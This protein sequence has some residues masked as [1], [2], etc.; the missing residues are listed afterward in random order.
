MIPPLPLPPPPQ[1]LEVPLH[2]HIPM[3]DLVPYGHGLALQLQPLSP[4]PL[5]PPIS[6][7]WRRRSVIVPLAPKDGAPLR[8]GARCPHHLLRSNLD[9]L[10]GRSWCVNI[11]YLLIKSQLTFIKLQKN[12]SYPGVPHAPPPE[13]CFT[14]RTVG[15]VVECL[16]N[17]KLVFPIT[18]DRTTERPWEEIDSAFHEQLST[19]DFELKR[20]SGD[21]GKTFNR[22][23]W[24]LMTKRKNKDNKI[25]YQGGMVD[26]SSFKIDLLTREA[27]QVN[28][29]NETASFPFLF[30]GISPFITSLPL[31]HQSSS[32][33]GMQSQRSNR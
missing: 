22:L 29:Q 9:V 11:F 8:P 5:P 6:C 20:R 31:S 28:L 2:S 33:D 1:S 25:K 18:L 26:V 32:P 7:E 27:I 17:N 14:N 21:D 23:S 3:L 30:L 12:M 10:Y 19:H 4:H 15:E 16:I 24:D 13:P